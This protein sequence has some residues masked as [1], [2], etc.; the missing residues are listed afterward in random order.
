M[1]GHERIKAPGTAVAVLAGISL[2]HLLNDTV[3]SLL[4]AIYPMLKTVFSLS[5]AQVGL[6]TLAQQLTASL[7]QPLVGLYT[8]R[9]PTPYSL[10]IGMA[11]TLVGLLLLAAAPTFGIILVAA[12]LM[13]IGSAVFHPESSRV[14]RMASGGRHG[15]AQSVFQV[16]GNIGTSFGPLLGAFLVLPRGQASIAWCALL[17]LAGIAVLWKIGGWHREWRERVLAAPPAPTSRPRVQLSPRRVGWSLTIL[18]ALIFSKYFYLASLS[19]YYTFYLIEKFHLSVRTAQIQ[20]FV[21]LAAVALG[22]ILGGPIGDRIGRK[23]VIWVSILGVLP[24]TLLLPY[25]SLFWTPVL[26]IVIGL[27]LASAFSAIVVFAQELV[28]GRVGLIS[29]VFFGFAFGMGGIGAAVLG[30]M[31]DVVG[32]EAVY[33]LCAFLPAIGLLAAFLPDV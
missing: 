21:F 6:M 1:I 18:A 4:P 13:G 14:A 33:R 24:F 11:F 3:Q 9:R 30:Q 32:I 20:L 10:V 15:L 17:A 12:L 26:A 22:T 28:P 8:D 19:S 5:F 31:A 16:G 25:A 7:L 29:G 23:L 2:S 27:I